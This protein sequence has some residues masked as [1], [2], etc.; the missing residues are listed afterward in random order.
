MGGEIFRTTPV[1]NGGSPPPLVLPLEKTAANTTNGSS[2]WA[3]RASATGDSND[4]NG[5]G[6]GRVVSRKARDLPVGAIL[7]NAAGQ[8]VDAELSSQPHW[9]WQMWSLKTKKGNKRFCRAFHLNSDSCSKSCSYTHEPLS[10]EEKTVFRHELRR[11][12]CYDGLKCRNPNCFY[13]HN[14]SCSL[15]RSSGRCNFFPEM[16]NVDTTSIVV[17]PVLVN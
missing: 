10:E 7:L 3:A 5:G 13:G 11:E 1:T 9:A 6:G 4:N 16:H 15:N 14:C 2:T 12:R 8:R 17:S